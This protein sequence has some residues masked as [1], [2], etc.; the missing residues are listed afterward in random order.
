[1]SSFN[2]TEDQEK[3]VLEEWNSRPDSP[4]SLLELIRLAFP[5]QDLDGRTKEGKAVKAFLASRSIKARAAHEYKAKT[6]MDLTEEDEIF[7]KNNLEFMSS[8]EM[9]RIL[10]K[11]PSL[12]NLNQEARVV[13][14][15]IKELEPTTAFESPDEVPTEKYKPPK[16]FDKT[17]FKV[18]KY[19]NG[20]INKNKITSKIQKN[21][22][23]L[24]NYINTYRFCYQIN[25]YVTTTDREL[26]ESSFV[27]Y[28]HDKPDLTQEEVDQY[29]VLS[30]EVVISASIQR[31]KEHLT[32]LLD[33]IVEDA[34][35][36]ASMSLVEA[37]GKTE[38][39]YNQSV[40]RQQKLLNDLKEKRS[41]RLKNQ[42][43]E[44]A[45]IL[46]LV[47]VWKD[48]ESRVKLIKLS[49]IRRKSVK[50]EAKN[51]SSMDEIKAR[52]LGLD[53]DEI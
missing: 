13:S 46:N 42:I 3:I 15:F 5:N 18:N 1:M 40:N 34:N 25:T 52:I 44:N 53:E 28:T 26:F 2:L 39:E 11:D 51:L 7:I 32:G 50:D 19:T 8:V 12:S 48:E 29:I 31:R 37:I 14:D 27:R 22:E 45:S 41:D 23:S 24:I 36:R 20:S 35:G 9:A 30:S 16:T 47:K 38:T 33:D 21:I 43:K 4:P 17:L 49:E 6:K 10:F